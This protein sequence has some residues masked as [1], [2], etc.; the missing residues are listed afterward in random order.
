MKRASDYKFEFRSP[1]KKVR[2]E[3]TF[4]EDTEQCNWER[5][6]IDH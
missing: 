4:V 5:P 2:W 6:D 3:A 1:P